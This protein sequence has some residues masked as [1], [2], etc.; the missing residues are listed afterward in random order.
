MVAL[1]GAEIGAFVRRPDAAR[2]IVLVYGPDAGLVRERVEALVAASVDDPSDPFSLVRLEADGLDHPGRLAEEAHTVPLFGGRRAVWLKAGRSNIAPAIEALAADP[3][4]DC[5]VVIEAGDLKRDSA[6]RTVCEK[7][8]AAVAL[9]C[10]V[11]GDDAL[12]RLIDQEMREAGLSIAPDARTLLISLVGGDRR[13]S[14][15]EVRKLALYAHGSGT[16]EVDDVLAVV[17]DASALALDE[18]VDAVFAGN[19]AAFDQ[20]FAR[21]R[22]GGTPAATVISA[23]FRHA[24]QLHRAKLAMEAGSPAQEAIR[25]GFR[26]LFFKREGAV[27]AA[28]GNWTADKLAAAMADLAETIATT[29]RRPATADAACHRALLVIAQRARRRR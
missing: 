3:P 11:D 20:E 28:L 6:L 4:A 18:V 27:R 5:R 9:P 29:R 7:A 26:G 2:P 23:A 25:A 24:V 14:R 22:A 21:V 10:Y 1:K 12:G 16:V 13:A 19:V 15:G 17:A 8:R